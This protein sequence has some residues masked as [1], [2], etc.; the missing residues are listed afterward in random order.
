MLLPVGHK[1]RFSVHLKLPY[2]D[3]L[4]EK[5]SNDE[6]KAFRKKI[7]E[8]VASELSNLDGFVFFDKTNRYE[9]RL[10]RGWQ[11]ASD[12]ESRK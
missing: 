7:K 10:P 4:K 2:P 8:Y 9:I 12:K 1:I 3:K 5:A 6:K 11:E